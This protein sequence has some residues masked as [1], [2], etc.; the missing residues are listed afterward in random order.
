MKEEKTLDTMIILIENC[1]CI[2]GAFLKIKASRESRDMVI[3]KYIKNKSNKRTMKDEISINEITKK[4]LLSAINKKGILLET[5]AFNVLKNQLT[6]NF[7]R[8]NFSIDFLDM[9]K[10]KRETEIDILCRRRDEKNWGKD[11]FHDFIMECKRTDY[12]WFFPVDSDRPSV[13]N[14]IEKASTGVARIQHY[15]VNSPVSWNDLSLKFD[16]KSFESTNKKE[17]ATSYR[18]VHDAVLQVLN[19]TSGWF[20]SVS[21]EEKNLTFIPVVVTNA[22]LYSISFDPND[23]DSQGNLTKYSSL[24]REPWVVYNISSIKMKDLLSKDDLVRSV[25]IVN[26]TS[27]LDFMSWANDNFH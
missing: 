13:V 24:K 2:V 21:I 3:R 8:R 22:K 25:I 18:D 26:V 5:Q 15:T 6:W 17:I 12:A 23:M 16:G 27:L 19:Q 11:V 14:L 1:F 9:N 7:I 10:I 4:Q 20:S